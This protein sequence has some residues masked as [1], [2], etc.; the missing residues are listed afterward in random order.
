MPHATAVTNL[1]MA[2]NEWDAVLAALA[3]G[4]Q[5]V[6][7]RKGGIAERGGGFHPEHERFLLYPTFTHQ[8]ADMLNPPWAGRCRAVNPQPG[9]ITLNLWAEVA[10]VFKLSS[11][12]ANADSI[13]DPWSAFHVYTPELIAKRFAYRPELPLYLML[14]RVY[15]LTE[16]PTIPE[17]ADHNACRSWVTLPSPI[18]VDRGSPVLTQSAFDETAAALSSALAISKG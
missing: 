10:R 13:A 16:P 2:F 6:L 5:T 4:E 7:L 8:R 18:A 9:E 1:A 12:A 17:P 14:V 3:A 15:R 11:P